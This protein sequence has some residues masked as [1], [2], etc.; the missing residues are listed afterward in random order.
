MSPWLFCKIKMIMN[1]MFGSLRAIALPCSKIRGVL[2]F[3]KLALFPKQ[4]FLTLEEGT[5]VPPRKKR[6]K[7]KYL[8]LAIVVQIIHVISSIGWFLQDRLRPS[9]PPL[10]VWKLVLMGYYLT[11]FS[12]VLFA[13]IHVNL[14]HQ[15]FRWLLNSSIQ[16][17][18]DY[19]DKGCEKNQIFYK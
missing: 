12:G 4:F 14:F 2:L 18:L 7:N 15:E 11:V 8:I 19:V 16:I 13:F 9:D 1:L 10:P 6:W 3:T 17:E 5:F